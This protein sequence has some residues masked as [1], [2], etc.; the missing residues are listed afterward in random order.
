[1]VMSIEAFERKE[2]VL[3]LQEKLTVAEQQRLNGEPSISLDEA[4]QRLKE[5]LNA[6]IQS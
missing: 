1:V 6:K 4:H 3:D 2:A 5:K